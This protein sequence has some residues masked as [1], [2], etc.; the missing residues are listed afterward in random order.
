MVSF[1]TTKRINIFV[2]YKYEW[3][4]LLI[5]FLFYFLW[6]LII[7]FNNAPDEKMRFQVAEFI[8]NKGYLPNG[9]EAEIRDEIW[10]ISYGLSPTLSYFISSIFM[11]IMSLFNEKAEMIIL[12]ARL[13]SVF[14]STV[15]VFFLILISKKCFSGVSQWVFIVMVSFLPQFIFI[16]SYVNNDAL[17][18]MSTAIIFYAWVIGIEEKWSFK[19]CLILGVGISLCALSYYNAYGFILCSLIIFIGSNLERVNKKSI[20]RLISKGI[21]ITIIVVV[22]A[23]WWFLRNYIIH[24]GDVFGLKTSARLSE[25]YAVVMQKPSNRPTPINFGI[26]PL[27]MIFGQFNWLVKS[28]FSAIGNFGYMT[29][30]LESYMYYIYSS[31]FVCGFL[32]LYVKMKEKVLSKKIIVSQVLFCLC[33]VLAVLI[34][35]SLSAYY[36]YT[37]DFQPQGRYLLTMII[38]FCYIITKGLSNFKLTINEKRISIEKITIYTYVVLSIMIF[39][40]KIL[41][42]YL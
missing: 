24:N 21:F 35:I 38:P 9:T 4:F 28:Y 16:S 10:G 22:L 11:R 33:I 18:I 1:M 39:C 17:A 34:P 2:R 40:D 12:S 14:C 20:K 36:S 26:I 41:Y 5:C 30:P 27:E 15:T 19:A 23:G 3:T 37:S 31:V 42:N 6:A 29:I 8:F 32:G 13:V 7:P 25:L